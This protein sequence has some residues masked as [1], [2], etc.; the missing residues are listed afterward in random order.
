MWLL[1]LHF[2]VSILCLLTGLGFRAIGRD[3]YVANGWAKEEDRKKLNILSL[4]IFFIPLLN[5]F[6]VMLYLLMMSVKKSDYEQW[7]EENRKE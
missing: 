1:K 4:W 2:S 5:V 3:I 6:T 7:C